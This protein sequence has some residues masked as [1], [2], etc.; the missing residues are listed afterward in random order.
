MWTLTQV[1][2]KSLRTI[3]ENSS[4]V[5]QILRRTPRLQMPNWYL[6]AGCIAQTVW[7]SLHGFEL[8]RN[9][10]DYDLAYFD[11]TDLSEET[12]E[13]TIRKAQ[14]VLGDLGV[15][16]DVKN[17]ARVHLWYKKHFGNAI[18]PYRSIED[19]RLDDLLSMIVRPNMKQA[20]YFLTED[21]STSREVYNQ[22]A[23]KW[24]KAWPK[25]VVVPWETTGRHLRC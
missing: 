10:Q 23:Q 21:E 25:L 14:S 8:T 1:D 11:S 18:R 16:I 6:G 12:E 3:L 24:V 20:E 9:I 15:T 17:E 2:T 7:N 22:K 19:A 13:K 5:K 4:V